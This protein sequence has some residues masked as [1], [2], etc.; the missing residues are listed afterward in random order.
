M[1]LELALV[2]LGLV[3]LGAVVLVSY[4]RAGRF[5]R[6]RQRDDLRQSVRPQRHE[7]VLG[8]ASPAGDEGIVGEDDI[9]PLSALPGHRGDD[10]GPDDSEMFTPRAPGAGWAS[11]EPEEPRAGMTG[12]VPGPDSRDAAERHHPPP[13]ADND[14]EEEAPADAGE[15]APAAGSREAMATLHA[16]PEQGETLG[17]PALRSIDPPIE[18]IAHI[19]G[20][21]VVS[22]EEILSPSHDAQDELT[23]PHHV[24]AL[25]H[26]SSRW[27]DLAL[28]SEGS[29][30]TDVALALQLV[31]RHGP[32]DA[33]QLD[34]FE[35]VAG[36]IAQALGRSCRFSPTREEAQDRAAELDE[37]C[38]RY[39]ALAILNILPEAPEGFGG[40]E[41][42]RAARRFGMRHGDMS[43][44]HKRSR[45]SGGRR[46]YSLANLH[47]PGTFDPATLDELRSRGLTVFM[48]IPA[49]PDPSRTFEDMVRTARGIAEA[50]NGRLVDQDRNPLSDDGLRAIAD[51]IREMAQNME[52]DGITPGGD[53]A[54]RLF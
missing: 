33:G 16:D 22:R 47:E 19:P 46:L 53:A 10:G 45:P 28:E 14:A 50:L 9:P 43:I 38:K 32:V 8:D 20:D 18:F 5:R 1:M 31:D 30:Y 34:R 35:R 41:V 17:P 26:P 15:A 52:R 23:K 49:T 25:S 37:V 44:Y 21:N 2:L 6:H 36:S 51:Q 29:R 24:Y 40:R 39:D 13:R 3:L 42:D 7:P 54:V 48:N 12:S 11:G 4:R 27:R